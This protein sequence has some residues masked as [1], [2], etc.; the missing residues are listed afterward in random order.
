MPNTLI[1]GLRSVELGVENVAT[2]ERFYVEAWGLRPAARA[3]EAVYLRA[4]GAPHHVIA[5]TPAPRTALGSITL[6]AASAANID[7]LAKR[8]QNAGATIVQAP[9][10]ITEPGGGY[11]LAFRDPEGR[12][13]RVVA[14]DAH[15]ADAAPERDRP[16]RL[17]HVVLN[18]RDVPAA[19]KFFV[20]A[21]GFVL[22]DRTRIMDFV[23]CNRDHHSIAFATGG[24]ATLNHIA[25]HMPSLEAVMLGSGRMKEAG[26]PIEWGVGR[27]GPGNNVFAYFVAPGDVVVEYT[28]EV[29]QVGDEYPFHGPEHWTWPPGRIDHWGISA[30]PSERMKEAQNR[31]AFA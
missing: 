27:H 31:V 15:H 29:Q 5:L 3:G 16:E 30:P 14:G 6:S 19:S 23:R 24:A 18:S 17:A 10:R 26:F 12:L 7:T 20:D 1:T 28:G 8:L 25:F 22:S 21:L 9:A 11:G 13:F 2:H 4:T